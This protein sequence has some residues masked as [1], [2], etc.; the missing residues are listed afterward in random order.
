MS[1]P[2]NLGIA[3]QYSCVL[4]PVIVTGS[5]GQLSSGIWASSTISE[6]FPSSSIDKKEKRYGTFQ[7]AGQ[8]SGELVHQH[9]T[10]PEMS[11]KC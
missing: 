11:D 1:K 6:S 4:T 8:E 7:Q 5:P 3:A 10:D 2:Y 9:S